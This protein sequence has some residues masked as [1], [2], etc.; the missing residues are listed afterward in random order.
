MQIDL[1][2]SRVRSEFRRQDSCRYVFFFFVAKADGSTCRQWWCATRN[3]RYHRAPVLTFDRQILHSRTGL[4]QLSRIGFGRGI[5]W[6]SSSFRK[7]MLVRGAVSTICSDEDVCFWS[8]HKHE[9]DPKAAIRIKWIA[10]A[11]ETRP[12]FSFPSLARDVLD[13]KTK[14]QKLSMGHCMVQ[15]QRKPAKIL[16]RDVLSGLQEAVNQSREKFEAESMADW[17]MHNALN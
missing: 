6:L 13:K 16:V 1:L 9:H 12:F 5:R 3:E 7:A 10:K 14:A 17:Y 8:I 4:E 2:P 15:R 11:N